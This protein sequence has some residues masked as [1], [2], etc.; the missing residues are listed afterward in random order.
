MFPIPTKS[1]ALAIALV[2]CAFALTALR[3]RAD[4][5]KSGVVIDITGAKR[6]LYP[7]AVPQALDGDQ[8]IAHEVAQT[9]SFDL[10]IASVFKVFDP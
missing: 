7:I 3:A 6:V 1:V 8:D 5:P 9:A 4:E 10:S 2:C